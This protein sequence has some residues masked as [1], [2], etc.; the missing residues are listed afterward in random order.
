[1]CSPTVNTTLRNLGALYRRQGKLEAAET[2]EECAVRSRKQVNWIFVF[3]LSFC[4][5]IIDQLQFCFCKILNMPPPPK[6][7]Y[8]SF[9]FSAMLWIQS[10][11]VSRL[12]LT[13]SPP[14]TTTTTALQ[15]SPLTSLPSHRH[16]ICPLDSCVPVNALKETENITSPFNTTII[17][18]TSAFELNLTTG[19]AFVCRSCALFSPGHWPHPPDSCGGDLEGY[20]WRQ[21]SEPWQ[22]EQR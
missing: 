5:Q 13:N 8:I 19:R 7:H 9:P 17:N 4:M 12:S 21:A 14:P 18:D 10:N 2:L 16:L 22:P 6:S 11:T 15:L 20:G 3:L 1:V